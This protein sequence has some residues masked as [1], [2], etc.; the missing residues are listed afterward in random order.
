MALGA[1][2][3]KD[4]AAF[5]KYGKACAATIP[6]R[7]EIW[8]KL[9]EFHRKKG[10]FE[11][12]TLCASTAI[13]NSK[14]G[15][16]MFPK[17]EPDC[18]TWRPLFEFAM[19]GFN[20]QAW[21]QKDAAI[22]AIERALIIPGPSW[23]ERDV[24]AALY[25]QH[26]H[27]AGTIAESFDGVTIRRLHAG[28]KNSEFNEANPSILFRADGRCL[29]S[30]RM[31]N[32]YILNYMYHRFTAT[33]NGWQ[34]GNQTGLSDFDPNAGKITHSKQMKD[35]SG[36]LM[37]YKSRWDGFEDCRLFEVD[38]QV[39]GLVLTSRIIENSNQ[40]VL[41]KLDHGTGAITQATHISNDDIIKCYEKNWM[42]I[43]NNKFQF[44]RHL[45]P[46]EIVEFDPATK[47]STTILK[48]KDPDY[49]FTRIRGSSQLV[50]YN[51]GWLC[52][53][54]DVANVQ[55]QKVYMHRFVY[56]THDFRVERISRP[57]AF[58]RQN[59]EFCCGLAIKGD[60]AYIPFCVMDRTNYLLTVPV[61]EIFKHMPVLDRPKR[62]MLATNGTQ[63]IVA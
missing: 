27:Q 10:Q 36:M 46:F 58:L 60:V 32:Y 4:D 11:E 40:I 5:L 17:V 63:A 53:V 15:V 51:D 14:K 49:D 2:Y 21:Q 3:Q 6:E 22:L 62:N 20:T 54:H 26:L 48:R 38:G 42:P 30:T 55:P 1:L 23:Q 37:P 12:A 9:A 52:I 39:Y 29:L 33:D 28:L 24:L 19:S 47:K 25:T 34:F 18:Y 57:M 59:I 56:L 7:N 41:L 61:S 8:I 50:P 13:G 31:M 43:L 44:V 45:D 35:E 16:L